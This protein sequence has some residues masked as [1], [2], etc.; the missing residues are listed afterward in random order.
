MSEKEGKY[1]YCII[2]IREPKSFSA[3]GIGDRGDKL[4]TVNFKDI[5]AVVSNSP[6]KKYPIS[7][8][9]TI[10]HEKAIEEVMKDCTVLPVRFA[11]ITEDEEKIKEILKKKYEEFKN[12]LDKM[13]NKKELGFKAIFKENEIYKYILEE[14]EDIKILKEKIAN[15]PPEKTHHQRMQIG[16]MVEQALEEEKTKHRERIVEVLKPLAEEM[17]TNHAY[18]ERMIINAAFLVHNNKEE[19]FDDAVQ[20]LDT[21]HGDKMKIKYLGTVPPFNFVNLTIVTGGY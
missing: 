15:L 4:E 10:A 11:T 20:E 3:P 1:I 8:E 7:R 21:Q 19:E 12:L 14:Y 5:A 16:E 6:I 9:N 17:K 18:G 2:G 13:K